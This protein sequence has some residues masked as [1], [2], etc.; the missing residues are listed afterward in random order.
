MAKLTKEEFD[1]MVEA[2]AADMV[3]KKEAETKKEEKDIE[4]ENEKKE[5]DTKSISEAISKGM[6]EMVSELKESIKSE[7]SGI[8]VGEDSVDK[9][10]KRGFKT[11][12][13]FAVDVAAAGKGKVSDTLKKWEQ[14]A[15][16]DPTHNVTDMESAAYLIPDEWRSEIFKPVEQND[17]VFNRMKRVPME[18]NTVNMP[19]VNGYDESSGKVYGAVQAQWMDE[20]EQHTAQQMKFGTFSMSLKKLGLFAYMSYELLEDSPYTMEVLLRDSFRDAFTFE[21]NDKALRGTGA[22][23]IQGVLNAPANIEVAE[24]TGQ[25]ADTILYENVVNMYRRQ[26]NRGNAIWLA[27]EDTMTQLMLMSI[28]VGTSGIPCWQPANAAAGIPYDTLFGRP[29]FWNKHCSTVGDVGD[30]IFVDWDSYYLGMK[31]AAGD[32]GR[33]ET[34]SHLKFDYDQMAYKLLYR[35]DG[36]C[37]WKSAVTPPQATDTISPIVT[38][39]AR[40]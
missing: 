32:T 16:G 26:A 35:L 7:K 39:A 14:K 6:S 4:V 1:A 28:P 18:R 22:G 37:A 34:S 15:A 40:A 3:A 23:Q 17:F 19:Y 38:I 5:V 2:K 29:I 11:L 31:G 25:A 21:M 30:L 36:A 20:E 27:N 24:E 8:E 12:S 10:P 9:D 13:H 33:F